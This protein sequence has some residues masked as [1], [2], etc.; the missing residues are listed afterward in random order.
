MFAFSILA[1]KGITVVTNASPGKKVKKITRC[2]RN[3]DV[4]MKQ[5]GGLKRGV[6]KAKVGA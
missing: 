6:I 2:S 3:P 5:I 4:A 1:A